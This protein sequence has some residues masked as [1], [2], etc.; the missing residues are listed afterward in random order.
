MLVPVW[1]FWDMY[2][3][4]FEAYLAITVSDILCVPERTGTGE[5][6]AIFENVSAIF[7]N[8]MFDLICLIPW[9]VYAGTLSYYSVPGFHSLLSLN[10]QTVLKMWPLMW[11]QIKIRIQNFCCVPL[12]LHDF[13][14][15]SSTQDV[16]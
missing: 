7:T 9:A 5:S 2:T 3:S 14:F 15:C 4:S 11:T 6:A 16:P 8:L 1:Q 13:H 10:Y 12:A